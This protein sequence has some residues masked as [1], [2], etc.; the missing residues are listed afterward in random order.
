MISKIRE[1]ELDLIKLDFARKK[2]IGGIVP[3][4]GYI[5]SAYQAVHFFEILIASE[6][7]FDTFII[8]NPDHSGYGNEINLDTNDAWETPFGLSEIDTE[9]NNLLNFNK[10]EPAHKFEHSGEVMLPFL[11]Y[12][13]NYDFKI[14]PITM[15]VQNYYNAQLIANR[16]NLARLK[17][18][19]N[20]CI[21]ASTDFSHYLSPEDGRKQ[22]KKAIKKII[23]LNPEELI[24]TVNKNRIS[25]CGFGP[26]A[27]LL[28]YANTVSAKP[29]SE[30]L[31]YGNSGDIYPSAK[32]VDYASFLIYE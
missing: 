16:I 26:V 5:Y 29:K 14:V 3:H 28:E 2:I 21:I 31:K 9:F 12:F 24:N 17:T 13:L 20:I 11:Q 15:S 30:L 4:A 10:S 25:M 18:N 22:D 32:V 6:Q 27:C 1:T 8:I 23:S 19:R 7:K